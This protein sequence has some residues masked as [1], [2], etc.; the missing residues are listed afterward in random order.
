MHFGSTHLV[1]FCIVVVDTWEI[2]LLK[3]IMNV[4]KKMLEQQ[5]YFLTIRIILLNWINMMRL[6]SF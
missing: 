6:V 3:L 4:I 2:L 1:I 5:G